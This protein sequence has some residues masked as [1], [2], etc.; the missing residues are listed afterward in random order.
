MDGTKEQIKRISKSNKNKQKIPNSSLATVSNKSLDNKET[1]KNTKIIIN[2]LNEIN[3]IIVNNP[4]SIEEE[5]KN[6]AE[7]K[8][9]KKKN[10]STIKLTQ[11]NEGSI[12]LNAVSLNNNNNESKNQKKSNINIPINTKTGSSLNTGKK[13]SKSKAKKLEQ[14]EEINYEINSFSSK[15]ENNIIKPVG[16]RSNNNFAPSGNKIIINN[17]YNIFNQ[18]SAFNIVNN[19]TE[20]E[21]K[22]V[23][24]N[25]DE[26]TGKSK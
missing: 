19:F 22:I 17:Y 8:S 6:K 25:V 3:P 7:V 1:I 15:D 2:N 10:K 12:N 14:S 9:N 18:N 5:I 20:N 11:T 24:I 21:N 23:I 4:S 16:I 13:S 26:E